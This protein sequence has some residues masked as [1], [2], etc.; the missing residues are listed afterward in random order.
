MK[1][2]CFN[3]RAEFGATKSK[4][5]VRL[6]TS[7]TVVSL[8]SKGSNEDDNTLPNKTTLR[9]FVFFSPQEN[10]R[11]HLRVRVVTSQKSYLLQKGRLLN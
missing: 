3:I 7:G 10:R 5:V 1:T 9:V 6:N 2:A 11:A 4:A 8:N